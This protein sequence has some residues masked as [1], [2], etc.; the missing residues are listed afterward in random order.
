M[1]FRGKDREMR[2]FCESLLFLAISLLFGCS[3][4]PHKEEAIAE[5]NGEKISV[6]EYLGLIETLKPKDMGMDKRDRGELKNL[7]IKTLIRRQVILTEAKRTKV[8]LTD[9]ELESGIEKFKAGYTAGAFE[10]SLLEQM[11]DE[12]SWREKIKQNLLIEKMFELSKPKIPEPTTEE[13]LAFYG[14][15]RR[16]FIKNTFA[17]ALH[18]VVPDESLAQDLRRR[19]RANPKDFLKLARENS[20]GPEAQTDAVIA[21]EKDLMPEE[22]DRPLF[23]TPIGE[24]SKVI[25]SAYG[26]H[27]LKVINRSPTLNL[28]FHQVKAQIIA[29]LIQDRRQEWLMRFEERL[30]RSADIRYNRE[31]LA[32]L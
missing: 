13:A 25:Q 23:E 32:R 18:I 10:Q 6:G 29:R 1:E 4:L 3:N 5:V 15:N 22:I 2:F 20:I 14:S 21:V 28:D 8:L 27:I 16:L 30:I 11:V 31:L 19:L 7:V 9:L 12:A 24:I 26:F 17:K